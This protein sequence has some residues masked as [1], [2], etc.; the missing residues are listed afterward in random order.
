A[1]D[2]AQPYAVVDE[3]GGYVLRKPRALVIVVERV[4]A[5][6]VE[7][8][9]EWRTGRCLGQEVDRLEPATPV[10]LG[11]GILDGE[12]RDVDA[13]DLEALLCQVD[14]VGARAAAD[15]QRASGR[16]GAGLDDLDQHRIGPA[17]V[18]WER[19]F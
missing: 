7:D 10:R 16:D 4:K 6:A 3:P 5:A 13:H 12:R 8:E 2:E 11:T 15:I 9:L 1:A 17:R 18:P 19:F 14:G